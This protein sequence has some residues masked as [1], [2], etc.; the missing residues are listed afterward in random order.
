VKRN[1]FLLCL[2][3]LVFA[4]A[5]SSALAIEPLVYLPFDG[6]WTNYGSAGYGETG[7]VVTFAGSTPV[8]GAGIKGQCADITSGSIQST[9]SG[10]KPQSGYI[11]YGLPSTDPNDPNPFDPN[12]PNTFDPNDPN[13]FDPNDP[14][15]DTD[16]ELAL[17][18]LKAFT[19]TYWVND[20]NNSWYGTPYWNTHI[21]DRHPGGV[22]DVFHNI[23]GA[24][25][26]RVNRTWILVPYADNGYLPANNKWAFCAMV[27]DS[28]ATLEPFGRVFIGKQ[29]EGGGYELTEF[30]C[31]K[32][33]NYNNA[34]PLAGNH[35]PLLIGAY[36]MFGTWGADAM[37]D[38]FRIFGSS[39]DNTGALTVEQL[40]TLMNYDLGAA[41]RCGDVFHGY[42]SGDFTQDC[43]TDVEDLSEFVKQWLE[44]TNP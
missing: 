27:Y 42:P 31:S 41:E 10:Y 1:N 21:C 9:P 12:D 8:F 17:N 23:N 4:V 28:T 38:E 13:T 33:Y 25:R 14:N 30:V 37:I 43:I 29:V 44:N 11:Y 7:T 36:D 40:K 16:I 24:P 3:V 34:G 5:P 6:D 19:I 2:L 32:V 15:T 18:N 20:N 35:E 39:S 22:M 26:L